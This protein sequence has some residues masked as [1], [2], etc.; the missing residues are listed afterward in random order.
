MQSRYGI[1]DDDF[2]PSYVPAYP[3]VAYTPNSPEFDKDDWTLS[4]KS[5]S[6][7]IPP[8]SV[9]RVDGGLRRQLKARHSEFGLPFL[10]HPPRGGLT[11]ED[12]LPSRTPADDIVF[13]PRS[14]YDFDWCVAKRMDWR[15]SEADADVRSTGGV[16]GVS[17]DGGDG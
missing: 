11:R 1:H 17:R 2:T 4:H 7:M 14:F 3:P 16:I 12:A 10:R 15:D 8:G 5:N 6:A 9:P 13:S